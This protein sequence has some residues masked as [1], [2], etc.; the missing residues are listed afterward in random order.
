MKTKT[1]KSSNQLKSQKNIENIWSQLWKARQFMKVWRIFN[2]TQYQEASDDRRL[3]QMKMTSDDFRRPQIS[4]DGF[5]WLR[6][7]SDDSGNFKFCQMSSD[8]L[9]CPQ[10]TSNDFSSD[11]FK[12]RHMT[13]DDLNWPQLASDDLRWPQIF[14]D[15][16]PQFTNSVRVALLG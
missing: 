8:D 15:S 5:R 4:W 12:W 11:D 6:M 1:I 10:M 9:V 14:A 16:G 2:E 7:T 13:S 3:L